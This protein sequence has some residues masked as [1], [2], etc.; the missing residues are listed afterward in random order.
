[1]KTK[2][3]LAAVLLCMLTLP[4][5]A[6]DNE[7]DP[8]N[9]ELATKSLVVLNANSE[10]ITTLT[11]ANI[12]PVMA[13]T[14]P[15]TADE[16]EFLYALRE[17][18]KLARDV[19]AAFASLFPESK[20]FERISQAESNHIAA[21]EKVLSYYE[22]TYPTLDAAGVFA[23]STRQATYNE[24]ITRGTSLIEAY[25]VT[26]FLEEESISGLST[27]LVDVDNDNLELL[28]THLLAASKNHLKA[29]VRQLA[30]MQ[31]IYEPVVLS[32]ELYNSIITAPFAM[33]N[34][35]QVHGQNG[36]M[37][38]TRKRAQTQNGLSDGPKGE[39]NRYGECVQT[40]YGEALGSAN[41]EG[42]VGKGYRGGR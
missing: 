37:T 16:I 41:G 13:V 7:N 30:S 8:V 20:P 38:N 19:T 22:I 17:D 21:I 9:E 11:T 18:E 36:L 29:Y 24:L 31:V 34:Q 33:G 4:F 39:V 26:A 25:K 1:M 3:L 15:L 35:Y 40:T 6:C 32:A 2:K 42:Q 14:N 27:V 28:V 23:D 12:I 5:T 10:G